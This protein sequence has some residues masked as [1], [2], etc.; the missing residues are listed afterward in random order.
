[1]TS[2]LPTESAHRRVAVVPVV[3]AIVGFLAF[4]VVVTIV[5]TL[6]AATSQT[7][8]P[9]EPAPSVTPSID[10]TGGAAPESSAIAPATPSTGSRC[11][12]FTAES[13]VLDID[14]VALVQS[15]GGDLEVEI[16]LT[17]PVPQGSAQLGIYAEP[18][19]DERAYQFL[20]NLDD[21]EIE[22]AI[23]YE[24]D[25]DKSDRMDADAVDINGEIVR[26]VVPRS[27]IKKLGDDWSWF[28][29]TTFDEASVDACPGEPGSFETLSF[30]RDD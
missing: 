25:R 29:F 21:G 28:A 16:T 13:D 15:D 17:S 10:P 24:F 30:D 20:V 6:A 3:I 14:Q 22:G 12:D 5:I 18:V 9:N 7:D 11:V 1:M 26:F 23:A 27:M 4:A 19:D 2:E 8:G